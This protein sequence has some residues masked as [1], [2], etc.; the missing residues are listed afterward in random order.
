MVRFLLP[1]PEVERDYVFERIVNDQ[2]DNAGQPLYRV[3]WMGY[4]PEEDT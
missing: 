1:E 3:R 4:N 2:S